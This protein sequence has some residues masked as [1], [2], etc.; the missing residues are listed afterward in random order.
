MAVFTWGLTVGVPEKV[1][2]EKRFDGIIHEIVWDKIFQTGEI[3]V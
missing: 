1:S 3:P 2:F